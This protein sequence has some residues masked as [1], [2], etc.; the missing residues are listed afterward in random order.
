MR[1]VKLS[2]LMTPPS[3]G[4]FSS[5][6]LYVYSGE[7]SIPHAHLLRHGENRNTNKIC[8]CLHSDTYFHNEKLKTNDRR[9]RGLSGGDRDELLLYMLSAPIDSKTSPP[10][11]NYKNRWEQ[12]CGDWNALNPDHKFNRPLVMPHYDKM[13]T[14]PDEAD[15]ILKKL[16][17]GKETEN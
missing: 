8:I 2:E 15:E 17:I 12:L 16:R 10:D 11:N 13:A 7:G 5:F 9:S 3:Y 4:G 1:L 14:S 6:T